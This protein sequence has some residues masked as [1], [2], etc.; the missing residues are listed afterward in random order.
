M[1]SIAA[2]IKEKTGDRR[3]LVDYSLL[4]IVL[5]LLSFG[6]VMLYSTSSYES[7][8]QYGDAAYFLK[9]QMVFTLLG[10]VLMAVVSVI[11]YT[12]WKRISVLAYIV[13]LG[14][15]LL[16]I[17]FGKEVNGA[18]RW[19]DIP[20]LPIQLQP[21]EVAKIGVIVFS[22]LFIE[23]LGRKALATVRGFILPMIPAV[24]V[25]V[26]L[27]RITDNLS[28]AIIVILIPRTLIPSISEERECWRG[29]T[30]R[31]MQEERDTRPYRRSMRSAQAGSSARD[32]GKVCRS[33]ALFPKRRTI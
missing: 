9:R 33:W 26:M 16:I 30:R 3:G 32:L 24:L 8:A 4:F 11:P 12:F 20:L 18:K 27:W 23:K 1:S 7:M 29:W 13:S 19:L 25:G 22:A 10:L 15:I 14:L 28:S 6:L 17:P 31:L 21:A 5:F 2:F